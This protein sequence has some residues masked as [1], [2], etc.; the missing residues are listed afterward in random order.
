MLTNENKKYILNEHLR[1]I[2]HISDKEYQRRIWIRGEGPECDDFDETCCHFFDD[3]DPILENY[4][5]FGIT[6]SQYQILK[7]FRKQFRTFSDENNW[8]HKF[9]ETPEWATIM[10][11]AKDVLKAF[12]YSK[13]R[14]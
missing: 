3:G 8:P 7:N 1:N 10:N 12:N 5:D 11:L 13:T 14:S 2:Y 9:I 4:K 6:E